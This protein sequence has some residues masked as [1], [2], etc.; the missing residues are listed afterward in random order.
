[1]RFFRLPHVSLKRSSVE[2]EPEEIFMDSV[3]A[4]GFH[5]ELAEGR[6]ERSIG[7]APFIVISLAIAAGLAIFAGRALILATVRGQDLR[8][9]SVANRTY[10]LYLHAPRGVIYDRN[11]SKLVTNISTFA[12]SLDTRA[13]GNWATLDRVVRRLERLL[14]IDRRDIALSNALDRSALSSGSQNLLSLPPK[15]F[16]HSGDL[17]LAI[18]EIQSKPEEFPG[19]EIEEAFRRAYPLES[20]ALHLVGFIGQPDADD[21]IREPALR[22]SQALGKSGLESRFESILRGVPGRK[23][24]EINAAGE[25]LRERFLEK[26]IA[27]KSLRLEVD[28]RLQDFAGR[29]LE[30]HLRAL[31]KRAGAI[32]LMDPRDGAVR[33]LVSYP[34]FD[35]NLFSRRLSAPEL[36]SLLAHPAKP[37]F[38]RAISGGYPSGSTIKPILALAALEEGI[39][40]PSRSIYDPGY[41]SVPNPFDPSRPT[42]YKDWKELGWVDMRRALALSA[43]VYF[44]TIGGGYRDLGGL[45]IERIKSWL[46]RFGWGRTLGIE[47]A[48]EYAGFLPDPENKKRVRPADP[49][50]RIGDTYITAIGQ[51]DIQ[52]TPLQL[53]ASTAAIANG[54]TLW[55]PRTVRAVITDDRGV[56]QE[57]PP[58]ALA[59][60]LASPAALGVV[61]EGMRLAVTGGSAQ[62]L[63]DLFFPVAGKTGTAET[64]AY[65]KNH[66]WFVGFAPYENPEIVM[67]VLVEEG[68]GGTTD[69]VP[70]AKEVLYYYFTEVNHAQL[71]GD[72]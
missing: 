39:I 51:G 11:F 30:R 63:A 47:L 23:L 15:L 37:F 46:D 53:A 29:T 61:R 70:I 17:R 50:W 28:S 19:V 67:V 42:I 64:G 35:P 10:P 22:P 52:V 58:A 62:A 16:I 3:N 43:N 69:A 56:L 26:P 66:G 38:N 21:L 5:P 2:I 49:T 72:R 45:G 32:V 12:I 8:A 20:R 41:I 24:V 40:D 1:M 34:S 7:P 55:Q 68:T 36:A 65:G 27:G 57:F 54:G 25:V 71:T 31:G 4:P 33:A 44:Y 60:N 14:E 59:R 48:G 13:I 9:R 6:L 18:L